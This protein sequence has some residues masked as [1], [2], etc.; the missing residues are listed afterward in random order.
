MTECLIQF[1]DTLPFAEL[2]KGS[3][4]SISFTSHNGIII[5]Q[6]IWNVYV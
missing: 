2:F 1:S 3:L 5:V 4:K 6:I